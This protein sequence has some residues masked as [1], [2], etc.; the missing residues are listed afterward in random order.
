MDPPYTR[1]TKIQDQ[2]NNKIDRRPLDS[3]STMKTQRRG[4]EHARMTERRAESRKR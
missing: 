4:N 2:S 3:E 1:E